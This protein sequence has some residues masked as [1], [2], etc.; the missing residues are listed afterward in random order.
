MHGTPRGLDG[1]RDLARRDTYQFRW[2]AVSLVDAVPQGGQKKGADR[3]IGGIR[4][5]RTGPNTGDIEKVIVSVKGGENVSVPQVRD[6][7]GTMERAQAAGGLFLTLA[8]PTR[9]RRRE[10][11]GAGFFDTGFGTHP[12]VQIMTI[13]ELLAGMTPDLPPLGRDEG[14]RRAPRERGKQPTQPKLDI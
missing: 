14:F 7:I 12:R 10:A 6:L 1:A 2:W 5:V 4:W 9:E 3:G 11:A 13:R 8:E